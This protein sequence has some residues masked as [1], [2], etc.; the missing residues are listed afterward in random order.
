MSDLEPAVFDLALRV[1]WEQHPDAL[2]ICALDGRVLEANDALL[3]RVGYS[4]E[5]LIELGVIP[6]VRENTDEFRTAEHEA[7]LAGEHRSNRM[8]GVTKDGETFRVEVITVPLEVDGTVVAVLGIARDIEALE[9]EQEARRVIE[10]RFEAALNSISDG[11][12]FLDKDFR[13]I[14]LNPRGEAISSRT[15]ADLEGKLIWDEFPEVRASEFGIG[16]LRAMR[17][18]KTIVVR[19][20]Y[21]P[22]GL[23]LEAT[24]YPSPDGIAIYVRDV[25]EEE[26]ARATLRERDHRIA[27]QAALLDKT[28]DA[29]VVR[30]LDH[31]IQYWNRGAAAMYGWSAEEAIGQSIRDLIYD[32]AEQFD[33]ATA[34]VMAT[35]EWAGDVTQVARDGS[36]IVASCRWSLVL[37]DEGLPEAI[38][39][40]NS[41]VTERRR[42]DEIASREQRMKSL[43]T[44]AGG[45]AHDLNNVLTPLLMSVQLLAADETDAS[46]LQTLGVVETSVKRGA[47]MIR[48]VLSFARGV[49]GRRIPVHLA[50]LVDDTLAFCHETLP[51]NIAVTS[52]VDDGID[53]IGDPTQLLQV[54]IN[55][56]TNARD[57]L[58]SGGGIHLDVHWDVE[59]SDIDVS[60]AERRAVVSVTDTG[61]GIAPDVASHMFE[62]FFTTKDVGVGTGLGLAIC[63]AIVRSH[64]GEMRAS[65]AT[66]QGA[67]FE[68]VLPAVEHSE[69]GT[70]HEPLSAPRGTGQLVLIV[71]DEEAI[72]TAA[73]RVLEG[74]GYRTAVAA[75]GGE[76]ITYLDSFPGT[77]DLVLSDV[78]MPE[79]SG[80]AAAATIALRHPGV[81][82]LFMS[83]R[84]ADEG[85]LAKPFSAKDLV[86]AVAARLADT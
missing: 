46:K 10:E 4:R 71:D 39:A 53:V 44:L 52:T 67:R 56:V 21:K 73:R 72:R 17:E 76:A 75:H 35:G 47:E 7:A 16:Y 50:R 49:D 62:P 79:V 6:V 29:M 24:V 3:R 14:Y 25:T 15:R 11:I 36:I 9:G 54:V 45:I 83:G 37:D 19:E 34:V 82:M 64:G 38:F 66:P 68:V 12:Y 1:V 32:E 13:F 55:L 78:S 51:P 40:V 23:S 58:P 20:H 77:V 18:Q 42:I 59:S 65:A 84:D 61:P 33:A 81:P 5:Q 60:H 41:D 30:G 27:S 43:G 22:L 28:G 85:L 74:Y 2:F 70:G 48:Q 63:A 26:R 80:R 69:P 8:T 86:A 31:T 57:V